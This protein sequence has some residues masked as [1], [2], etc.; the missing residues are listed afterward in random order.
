MWKLIFDLEASLII[1]FRCFSTFPTS[2]TFEHI[3]SDIMNTLR[4]IKSKLNFAVF[5]FFSF[6]LRD[7]DTM[8]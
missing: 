3:H 5:F 6:H 7:N 2:F 8:N 4:I 1:L